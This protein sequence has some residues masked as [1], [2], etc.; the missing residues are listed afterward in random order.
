MI[1]LSLAANALS[2][3]VVL[4]GAGGIGLEIRTPDT[5]GLVTVTTIR[6]LPASGLR[7]TV[8]REG[9]AADDSVTVAEVVTIIEAEPAAR[10]GTVGMAK[11]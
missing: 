7:L 1:T 3:G 6:A 2:R 9:V 5:R 4:G 11:S 8:T 10:S